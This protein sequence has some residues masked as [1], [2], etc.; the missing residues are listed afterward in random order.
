MARYVQETALPK[1]QEPGEYQNAVRYGALYHDIGAYLAFNN[2]EE[3]PAAG[4]KFLSQELPRHAIGEDNEKIILDVVERSADRAE[5]GADIPVHA[6]ICALA[7]ALDGFKCPAAGERYIAKNTGS[8]FTPEASACYNCAREEI[9]ELYK[10]WRKL[11][12]MCARYDASPLY[13]TI[14]RPFG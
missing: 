10:R 5:D 14:D 2:R 6:A 3:Y 8:I 12:P 7:S 1:G 4:V 11:P 9:A 13:K